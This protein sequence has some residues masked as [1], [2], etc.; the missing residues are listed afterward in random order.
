[1][2]LGGSQIIVLRLLGLLLSFAAFGQTTFSGGATIQ[3]VTVGQPT[4]GG[5]L[6]VSVSG[7]T[8]TQAVL[9]YTAPGSSAC[10]VEVSESA[11]Y[12]PLVHD[13][14]SSLFTGANLDSR[15]SSVNSG[16]SRKVVIGAR[17]SQIAL[18]SNI[19]SRALQAYT[20]HYFRTTCGSAVATG[21]FTTANIPFQ[22][23]YADIPQTD[24]A[25]PGS[26]ILPNLIADRTQTIVD[27]HTGA[28]IRRVSL[29]ADTTADGG[30]GDG[31]YMYSSGFTRVC[32]DSLQAA[33]DGTHGF[34][35]SYAQGSGGGQ[36]VFYYI[37]PSTAEVRYL[38][39]NNWGVAYPYINSVDG[40]FYAM[41]GDD[42]VVH[43]YTGDYTPKATGIQISSSSAT[44]ISGLH[45]AIHAF[46]SSF[47]SA[48]FGCGPYPI[49]GDYVT[50]VCR[51]GQADT[52]GWLAIGQISTGSIVAAMRVD[53]NIKTRQCAIHGTYSLYDQPAI[54]ITT[55]G[56]INGD[57]FGGGPYTTTYSGGSTLPPGSTVLSVAGELACSGSTCG[58]DPDSPIAQVGDVFMFSD[59]GYG[60]G[61]DAVRIVTKTSTTSWVITPTLFAHA[62][63][64]TLQ[65]SC[66]GVAGQ[67]S[68]SWTPVFWKFLLDPH[69]IDTTNT[70]YVADSNWPVG[71]HDDAVTNLLFTENSGWEFRVGNL[72]SM[73]GQPSTGFVGA[74]PLFAGALAN[75][76]GNGCVRHQSVAQGQPWITDYET[77]SGSYYIG[78]DNTLTPKSGQVYKYTPGTFPIN[79]KQFAILGGSKDGHELLDVSPAVLATSS[80]DS[81]K[82]C[83][84]NAP[85]ECYAGSLKGEVYANLPGS[86]GAGCT[87]QGGCIVNF[88]GWVAAVL[89]IGTSG[90]AT[91]PIVQG[92]GGGSDYPTAKALADGSYVLFT[93]RLAS[94]SHLLM[95]KLPP[96]S[97]GDSVDR[98]TFVRAPIPITPP[99]GLGIATAT[100]EFGYGEQGMPSQHYCT[101]RREACVATAYTVV[102][103]TPFWYEA[104]DFT[105]GLYTRASC[106]VS[107]TI[108]LPVLPMHVAYYQVRFYNGAGTF[109]A[110]GAAG[111]TIEGK[112]N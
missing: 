13:V 101:S 72:L 104:T 62:P 83:V 60:A 68:E 17:M 48:D 99:S 25:T 93:D 74:S 110:S 35:C 54:G 24:P 64:V 26:G 86:P 59:T 9:S 107:C 77:W 89:Q 47:V 63:G 53:S 16:T 6:S 85:G 51:R 32:S 102:D 40:K 82:F 27:P 33:P 39:Y 14:D 66:S 1:M 100:V 88:N 22:M 38:G 105:A 10:T 29:P 103:A 95:A 109:V 67:N 71:G 41:A 61:Q 31:P 56:F 2:R 23:T 70:N 42:F 7:T 45:A 94:Q 78:N 12:S 44:I 43:T 4:S 8:N 106:A 46:D 37:I 87:D 3:N 28:L 36:G 112:A 91:R 52:Y 69:G 19:Y 108:T 34:L 98:T 81:Y 73:I 75:C 55:H 15:A 80:A 20:T 84:A 50:F 90:T 58:T 97:A 92:F 21:T 111:I 57:G 11:T 79:P 5:T 30:G 76:Y 49:I 96:F 65:G 18:D